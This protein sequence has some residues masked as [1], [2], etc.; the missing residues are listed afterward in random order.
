MD[1]NLAQRIGF[2][3][4]AIPLALAVVWYG[5]WPLVALTAVV[6]IL[7]ARELYGL[8]ALAGARA[9]VGAGLLGAALLPAGVYLALT[10]AGGMMALWPHAAAAWLLLVMTAGLARRAP[11]ERPLEAVA[12]TVFGVCYAAALPAFLLDLRHAAYGPRSWAGAWLVFY[13]LV[14]TWVGDTAAMFGG[15]AIGGPKL[16][17]RVSPGKTR[18]GSVAGVIGAL[19]VAPVFHVW[20]FPRAGV[21]VSLGT[22]LA[23]AAVL[24][25]VGQVGDL[26]ESLFKREAGVKDSSH[27]IPGHGGVLDRFDSLYFVVPTAAA[28]YRLLGVR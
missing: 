15:R 5:G 13:P 25:V 12:T 9:L 11:A 3:A 7:G 14:V 18:A 2:A 21:T 16:A 4:V 23:I 1:R 6:A 8:L 19:L 28:L 27:L 10:A 17:P 24:S 26:A 20:V 22:L